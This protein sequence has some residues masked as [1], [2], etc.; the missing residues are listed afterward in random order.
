ML[1]TVPSYYRGNAG[2]SLHSKSKVAVCAVT[3]F[4]ENFIHLK[5]H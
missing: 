4:S 3:S 5:G 2:G 1:F